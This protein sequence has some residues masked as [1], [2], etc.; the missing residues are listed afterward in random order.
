MRFRSLPQPSVASLSLGSP[1]TAVEF[2][3]PRSLC[4]LMGPSHYFP[5]SAALELGWEGGP[6]STGAPILLLPSAVLVH[7][8]T[9]MLLVCLGH[10]ASLPQ[11][12]H[13]G[14]GAGCVA[15]PIYN[16]RS[17]DLGGQTWAGFRKAALGGEILHPA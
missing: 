11:P 3:G 15:R 9:C 14:K 13:G 7:G 16:L 4:R 17:R 10:R 6:V 1:G 12:A 8:H 5:S 2:R